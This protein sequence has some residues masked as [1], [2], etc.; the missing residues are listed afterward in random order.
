MTSPVEEIQ[1]ICPGCGHVYRDWHRASFNFS[2]GEEFSEEYLAEATSATC[3]KCRFKVRLTTLF[4]YDQTLEWRAG[5][6]D[7]M[8]ARNLNT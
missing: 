8:E 1:V 3:P 6:I 7:Q 5:D 4:A 2:L